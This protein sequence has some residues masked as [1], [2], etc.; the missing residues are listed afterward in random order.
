MADRS[1]DRQHLRLYSTFRWLAQMRFRFKLIAVQIAAAVR[2]GRRVA[3]QWLAGSGSRSAAS[4]QARALVLTL[5]RLQ[6][7][8]RIDPAVALLK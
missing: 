5:D 8:Q 6:L 7:R 1:L 4:L 3:V 2:L